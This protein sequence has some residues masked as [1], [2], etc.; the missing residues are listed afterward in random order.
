M[1]SVGMTGVA[2][3]GE[4]NRT[5]RPFCST[6]S[7]A[8]SVGCGVLLDLRCIMA[9][10][11]ARL[12]CTGMWRRSVRASPREVINSDATGEFPPIAA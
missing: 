1:L 2:K 6:D 12:M 4:E 11:V 9:E 3:G 7:L 5:R 10:R 8:A